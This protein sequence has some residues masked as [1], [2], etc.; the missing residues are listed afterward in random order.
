[1]DFVKKFR[2]TLNWENR[3]FERKLK[4]YNRSNKP[5][6]VCTNYPR[7]A[8]TNLVFKLAE[9]R[10]DFI[11]IDA[12]TSKG[13]GHNFL[14]RARFQKE[15]WPQSINLLYGHFPPMLPNLEILERFDSLK[16]IICLRSLSDIFVS[17]RERM[18]NGRGSLD[19]CVPNLIDA[20]PKFSESSEE[21]QYDYIINFIAPWYVSFLVSWMTLEDRLD[22][23]YI[24]F[25]QQTQK[26]EETLLEL[27][28]FCE[29][30]PD[31]QR[32]KEVAQ[33]DEK[34]NFVTGVPGRGLQKLNERQL[35]ELKALLDFHDV[36]RD[37]ELGNYLLYGEFYKLHVAPPMRGLAG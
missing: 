3:P 12:K 17:E 15:F 29:L 31:Y 25:E 18:V 26:I 23:K 27:H 35:S 13:F 32:I 6:V 34:F 9:C 20:C 16:I 21:F 10:E 1:M 5:L 37:T 30:P 2:D 22:I 4:A 7:S 14:D 28:E 8:S 24:R 33:K 11:K 19:W 36:F